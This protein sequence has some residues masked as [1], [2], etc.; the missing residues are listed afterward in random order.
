MTSKKRTV[1]YRVP[2]RRYPHRVLAVADALRQ[3]NP[4]AARRY[5]EAYDERRRVETPPRDPF[6]DSSARAAGA[7]RAPAAPERGEP[8]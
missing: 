5:I 6:A 1:D 3:S 2:G 8:S 7:E 4:G